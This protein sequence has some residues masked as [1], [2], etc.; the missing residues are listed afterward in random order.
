MPYETDYKKPLANQKGT[1]L[2]SKE[3]KEKRER[4]KEKEKRSTT[5]SFFLWILP[6]CHALDQSGLTR[7]DPG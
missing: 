5:F 1:A 2:L 7:P 4:E 3:K 6:T